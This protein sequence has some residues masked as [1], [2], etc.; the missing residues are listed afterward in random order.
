MRL[1]ES[2]RLGQDARATPAT[3]AIKY[4]GGAESVNGKII[5]STASNSATQPEHDV[6]C[7]G[8][9]VNMQR[10]F[11]ALMST[12]GATTLQQHILGAPK[13]GCHPSAPSRTV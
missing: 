7:G 4:H 10:D 1:T 8:G 11:R 2:H 9:G 13:S 3:D 5:G 12:H 6:G